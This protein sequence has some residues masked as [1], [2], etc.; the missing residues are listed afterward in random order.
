MAND[1]TF[2][3]LS[4]VL[5]EIV[6]QATG[7]SVLAP[8]D[9]ASFVSVGQTALLAGYDPLNTAI[10]Q[11]LSR[12]IFS[13]RPYYSKFKGMRVNNIKWGNIT[14]K[15]TMIDSES[16]D[17]ERYTLTDGASVDQQIVCAPKALQLNFYGSNTYSR[18]R[19]IYR[20]QLDNAF[21]S[22]D[23]FGRFISM[24]FQN[25]ADMIDQ[26]HESVKRMTLANFIAGIVAGGNAS[27]VVHLLTEYNTATGGSY[28]ATT[29]MQ[30]ENYSAFVKWA[31]GRIAAISSMLTERSALYHT[32]ITGKTVMR[33]TPYEMQ[34]V[35]LFAPDMYSI[36]SRVLADAYHDNYLRLA[37]H[38]T[39]NYWQ[40]IQTPDTINVIPTY[41]AADGTLTTPEEAVTVNNIF[42][43]ICDEESLGMT[44]QSEWSAAAPFNAR[45]GYTTYYWHF[46]DKFWNDFTE[47]GVVLLLN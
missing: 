33:H 26:D 37:D 21:N 38:E 22:P 13:I 5:K 39:V 32:N 8:V 10:S 42:G 2:N 1:L 16:R 29:I 12:T 40:S 15:L 3:Q 14:R 20:D 9:T 41:L 24:I 34:R 27:Q 35:Y 45:G 28:T 46:T 43:I 31:Y 44:V 30:P 19:T 11:V 23:E 17:D 36:E 4:T 6:S 18:C 25:A 7:Q 47:N